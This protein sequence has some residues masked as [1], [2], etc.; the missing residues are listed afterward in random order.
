MTFDFRANLDRDPGPENVLKEFF[1]HC[2][3][4]PIVR[5]LCHALAAFCGIRVFYKSSGSCTCVV[6]IYHL[7]G[8]TFCTI[9]WIYVSV[10]YFHLVLKINVMRLRK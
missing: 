7:L 4:G 3:I 6:K 10:I 5:I 9:K 2:T 1:Y 8:R